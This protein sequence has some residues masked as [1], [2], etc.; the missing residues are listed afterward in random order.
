MASIARNAGLI[1]A[2][3]YEHVLRKRDSI[4][5]EIQLLEAVKLAGELRKPAVTFDEI[6]ARRPE[7]RALPLPAVRHEVECRL[8][9]SGYIARQEREVSRL[10]DLEDVALP[11]DLDYA[12]LVALSSEV[13]EK[14]GM[15]RP[16]TL[17][18]ASRIPGVTPAALSILSVLLKR[19]VTGA[20][21]Q[22]PAAQRV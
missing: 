12:G 17:G 15:V 2:R 13:R 4:H 7:G 10:R 1:G 8:K 3:R 19:E 11:A 5:E 9:Y 18:Q 21:R 6:A 20:K 22:S 14:L 16:V